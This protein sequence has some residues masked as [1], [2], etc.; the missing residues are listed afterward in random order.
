MM[1]Q[2]VIK[3]SDLSP[4][5]QA[6][7]SAPVP[8]D[9]LAVTRDL[10]DRLHAAEFRY[11][12]WKSNE[13]VG[14]GMQGLTDLDVLV[15]RGRSDDLQRI[16]ADSGFRRFQATALTAYPAVEDYLGFDEVTGRIVHLHLHHRLTLG[17]KHLK[18]YRLPWEEVVLASSRLDPE[19]GLQVAAPEMELLLLVVRDALKR[20]L[21]SR[22]ALWLGR[23]PAQG[24]FAREF[25]WLVERS[26]P[27]AV[28]DLAVR[29]IGAEA[30]AP[31]RRI[32][33][34]DAQPQDMISFAAVV[35]P[36]L[37][38]HRTYGR[39]TAA[40]LMPIREGFWALGG[41][42]RK[43]FHWAVPLR[44]ISPRG[45]VVV[46]F[47]GSDGA[48]KSTQCAGTVAWLSEKLD[49]VPVYFGSGDGPSSLLRLPLKFARRLF[50]RRLFGRHTPGA[51]P[52][53]TPGKN[54]T[55][56]R[57]K[58]RG[59]AM[60]FWALS[61]SLEKRSRLRRMVRA[62][63]RG[64]IVICDRFA[65]NQFEG[66]NDG[67]LLGKLAHSR[68]RLARALAAWEARPYE[69]SQ[70]EAPDLVIKLVA[71]TN[72]A[73]FRRPEMTAEEINRR[74]DA[75]RSIRFPDQTQDA[76]VNADQPLEA[77]T[78]SVRRLIWGVL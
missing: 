18:G 52:S 40:L 51:N 38:L 57:G 43:R 13:H 32:L 30:E 22:V 10:F 67:R 73:L 31:L 78:R 33:E 19:H 58:I 12:H 44:R 39:L 21:R 37:R 69:E 72:V 75:V 47:L 23:V 68:W 35:R 27:E 7:H 64:L 56:W 17:Q 15:E 20:R 63:N 65:Q 54:R 4:Q 49:V 55:G 34:Q 8:D 26:T 6:G 74:I 28:V 2:I 16:L 50:E 3:E 25:A 9:S 11:C 36:A 77:V 42:S 62:R 45:G 41:L 70:L 24:D 46:A 1:S 60:V 48:G 14:A 53:G 76:E 59:V 29:L 61:L 71:S 66:F 5:V